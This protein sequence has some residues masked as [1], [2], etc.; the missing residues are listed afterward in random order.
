MAINRKFSIQSVNKMGVA[1]ILI[2]FK[3]VLLVI[4]NYKQSLF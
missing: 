4:Q 3:I 2:H 1:D